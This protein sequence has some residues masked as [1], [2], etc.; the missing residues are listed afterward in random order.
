MW[1]GPCH[2]FHFI[3]V[4]LQILIAFQSPWSSIT[5]SKLSPIS[6]P[7]EL[8]VFSTGHGPSP[9][10]S[11]RDPTNSGL[12]TNVMHQRRIPRQTYPHS[13][14]IGGQGSLVCC[15]PWGCKESDVA[16]RLTE[17]QQQPVTAHCCNFWNHLS[18]FTDILF[19]DLFPFILS[20][21]CA[22]GCHHDRLLM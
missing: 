6:W 11:E 2:F 15:S 17:Q 8:A 9:D 3:C 12:V 7:F 22:P 10:P 5:H 16:E 13:N 4:T 20:Y 19:T 18:L 21:F 14:H 1:L